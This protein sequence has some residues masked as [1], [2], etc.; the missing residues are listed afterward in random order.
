[1]FICDLG[2]KDKFIGVIIQR[3]SCVLEFTMVEPLSID[4]FQYFCDESTGPF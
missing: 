2:V 4:K 3:L 1:M